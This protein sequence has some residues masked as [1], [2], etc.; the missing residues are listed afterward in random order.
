MSHKLQ[1]KPL[2]GRDFVLFSVVSLA[3]VPGTLE[4]NNSSLN[5]KQTKMLQP[6]YF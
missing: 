6:L 5:G 4:L 1:C 3:P 2:E